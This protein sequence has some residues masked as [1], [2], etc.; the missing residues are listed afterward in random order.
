M[1]AAYEFD[2]NWIY[3]LD[4]AP[5]L[6]SLFV[7]YP[8]VIKGGNGKSAIHIIINYYYGYYYTYIYM[9]GFTR[10]HHLQF[11]GGGLSQN[12]DTKSSSSWGARGTLDSRT[13]PQMRHV[14]TDP[15]GQFMKPQ[16]W[17]PSAGGNQGPSWSHLKNGWKNGKLMGLEA[18]F[19]IWY[20][21]IGKVR[22][23][24]QGTRLELKKWNKDTSENGCRTSLGLKNFQ[25]V[26][27]THPDLS[28][29]Q[30]GHLNRRRPLSNNFTI[31][32]ARLKNIFGI[33]VAQKVST[34]T[35]CLTHW[36][37]WP[38]VPFFP[39]DLVHQIPALCCHINNICL[40]SWKWYIS[41]ISQSFLGDRCQPPH[42]M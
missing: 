14:G 8:L 34:P 40:S 11:L 41:M 25:M 13:T 36:E 37:R 32:E 10:K 38:F 28:F 15:T 26:N 31:Q 18:G 24:L 33:T 17:E 22:K 39:D 2:V 23:V 30:L 29:S 20:N 42:S 1:G 19:N 12:R 35:F 27:E 3:N 6:L 4:T 5:R 7:T 16:Y 21:L 9:H